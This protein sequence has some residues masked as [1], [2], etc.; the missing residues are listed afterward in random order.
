MVRSNTLLV[1]SVVP[2]NNRN[3]FDK[4]R[5]VVLNTDNITNAM[6]LGPFHPAT[7]E[8]AGD[9]AMRPVLHDALSGWVASETAYKAFAEKLPVDFTA[10][11]LMDEM[12]LGSFSPM[13]LE[14]CIAHLGIDYERL[15]ETAA[16]GSG[17]RVRR[18]LVVI[19][20]CC[21]ELMV[22]RNT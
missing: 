18:W 19:R 13:L 16:A 5:A 4:Q 12:N 11:R 14:D 21:A 3:A 17:R 9:N 20:S 15:C 7:A 2:T 10:D 8:N 22:V 6:G 1:E